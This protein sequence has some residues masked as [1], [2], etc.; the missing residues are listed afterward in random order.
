MSLPAT[1][2][3]APAL[4]LAGLAL[5]ASACGSDAQ[6][7]TADEPLLIAGAAI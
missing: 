5:L 1:R 3:S 7:V 6:A 4:P 2:G